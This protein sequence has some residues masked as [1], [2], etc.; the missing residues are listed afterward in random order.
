MIEVDRFKDY[1]VSGFYCLNTDGWGIA[2]RHPDR[3]PKIRRCVATMCISRFF[4]INLLNRE[5]ED[6]TNT[7][8]FPINCNILRISK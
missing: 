8:S 2:L 5:F 4:K 1:L 3:K 6:V 7:K